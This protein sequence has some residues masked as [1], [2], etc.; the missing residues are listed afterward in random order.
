MLLL[1]PRSTAGRPH[2]APL[3]RRREDRAASAEAPA[4]GRYEK[5][6][7]G[8]NKQGVNRTR[9][10]LEAER[11]V[12]QIER[13]TWVPPR[14]EP[15]RDRLED[16]MERLGVPFDE[17]FRGFAERWWRS[18]QLDLA[19][20]TFIDYS[21][22][23]GYLQRVGGPHRQLPSENT[24]RH[25]WLLQRLRRWSSPKQAQQHPWCAAPGRLL[26]DEG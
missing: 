12:Q 3:V 22:R 9:A 8:T 23:L 7:F 16:A 21:W 11:I 17:T 20:K 5:I 1:M 4:Y 10:E 24:P 19:E 25:A 6:T 13:G 14:L 2:P 18:K 26:D 15:R